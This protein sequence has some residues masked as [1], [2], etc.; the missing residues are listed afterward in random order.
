MVYLA[1]VCTV[2]LLG[3]AYVV[4][5]TRLLGAMAYRQ[6][7]AQLKEQANTY[8]QVE[9]L[10]ALYRDLA[11][12]RGFPPLRAFRASP[13][14]LRE[15]LRVAQDRDPER[16]LECGSGSSTVFLALWARKRGHGHV[17]SLDHDKEYASRTRALLL[18]RGLDEWATVVHAPLQN[19]EIHG[20]SWPWYAAQELPEGPFGLLVVDGPPAYLRPRSRYPA[21]SMLHERLAPDVDVV[22]DDTIRDEEQEIVAQWLKEYPAF[23]RRDLTCEKGSIVL[24]RHSPGA[25]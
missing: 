13:D 9:A 3:V 15:L 16:I 4:R 25:A 20:E 22:L 24:S 23:V 10:L 6:H 1:V 17:W 7:V 2:A 8:A 14:F 21:L 12:E 18:E 19:V 11:P 5:K